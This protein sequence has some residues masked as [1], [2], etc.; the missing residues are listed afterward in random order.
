MFEVACARVFRVSTIL[1]V[2]LAV[3]GLSSCVSVYSDQD[4]VRGFPYQPL[5]SLADPDNVDQ[6]GNGRTFKLPIPGLS[7][8]ASGN[9]AF[10]DLYLFV[11]K[12][13]SKVLFQSLVT[14]LTGMTGGQAL[15][16]LSG[17][18]QSMFNQLNQI[19]VYQPN[20]GQSIQMIR[21]GAFPSE[22]IRAGLLTRKDWKQR[23]VTLG[24]RS[25][26]PVFDNKSAGLHIGLISQKHM[27]IQMDRQGDP[28]KEL[29][30]FNSLVLRAVSLDKKNFVPVL[31][32]LYERKVQE[33]EQLQLSQAEENLDELAVDPEQLLP[34]EVANTQANTYD[35]VLL[36]EKPRKAL[37]AL[38]SMA[39]PESMPIA[40][41][42]IRVE[43]MNIKVPDE[44]T[45]KAV[46]QHLVD[47]Q[48]SLLPR[49]GT[50]VK[51]LKSGLK[52]AMMSFANMAGL[53]SSFLS[54]IEFVEQEDRLIVTGLRMSEAS[55][56]IMVN[57]MV[58]LGLE[59]SAGAMV[60]DEVSAGKTGL[61]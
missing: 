5:Q 49:Q 9:Q 28:A 34:A 38:V 17:I 13:Q 11:E 50:T 40:A 35:M 47:F 57:E 15:P 33:A 4:A 12:N 55:A 3:F 20:G 45:G 1:V 26:L 52:F 6:M 8:E 44:S 60:W 43:P 36:N 24:D 54:A 37:F 16:F 42:R 27:A 46:D 21:I 25:V 41:V 31:T 2:A 56:A 19:L 14:S 10:P 58:K 59:A 53:D 39:M 22:L 61:E 48:A 18:D 30:R 29:K 51:T 23:Y 7:S 32:S